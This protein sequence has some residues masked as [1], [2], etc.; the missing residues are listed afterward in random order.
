MP[1]VPVL[2][3]SAMVFT[4]LVCFGVPVLLWVLLARGH[5][6]TSL[7]VLAGAAGFVVPQLV[8][9]LPL[10]SWLQT[11]AWFGAFAQ[12]APLLY[13]LALAFTAGLFETAGRYCVF[14]WL[15]KAPLS[16]HTAIA[17]G[18]GHGGSEAILLVGTTYINNLVLSLLINSGSVPAGVPSMDVLAGLLA[19]TPAASYLAAGFERLCTMAFHIFLTLLLA[20]CWA[21][22]KRSAGF[23]ACVG[24]HTLADTLIPLSNLYVGLWLAMVLLAVFGV[25]SAVLILRIKWDAPPA[26]HA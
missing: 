16:R 12:G 18:V 23:W 22:G 4:L 6:G 19:G 20:Y 2:S 14:R 24:L 25:A 26:K 1:T 9:R 5:R 13:V 8:I 17:A 15:V 10:L 21:R 11:T 3:I 7:V